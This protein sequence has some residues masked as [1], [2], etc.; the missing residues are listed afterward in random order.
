MALKE[1]EREDEFYSRLLGRIYL[2]R[3]ASYS[4][5][6]EFEKAIEDYEKALRCKGVFTE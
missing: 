1:S 2:K 6:S 4:W 5:I 3:G